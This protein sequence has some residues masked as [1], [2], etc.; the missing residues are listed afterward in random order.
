MPDDLTRRRFLDTTATAVAAGVLT[1]AS[2]SAKAS[3]TA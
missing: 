2:P 1:P 3:A